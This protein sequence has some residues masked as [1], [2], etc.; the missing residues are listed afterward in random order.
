MGT[1]IAE[2]AS[3]NITFRV[4]VNTKQLRTKYLDEDEAI[5]RGDK[6]A[7][8]SRAVTVERHRPNRPPTIIATWI[9]GVRQ[10][11]K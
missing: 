1:R 3:H 5:E 9:D 7:R 2:Y 11:G 10:G 6:E 8:S 4:T